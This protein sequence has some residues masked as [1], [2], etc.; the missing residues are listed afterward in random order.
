ML[1]HA[2]LS[3]HAEHVK[4][5]NLA[6]CRMP[7]K[8]AKAC[9]RKIHFW[10]R[11][12][13]DLSYNASINYQR[14]YA[15]VKRSK[16]IHSKYDYT[17]TGSLALKILWQ[18]VI[19]SVKSLKQNVRA[20]QMTSENHCRKCVT[21]TT[22]CGSDQIKTSSKKHKPKIF[23]RKEQ[24]L[25]LAHLG[26]KAAELATLS[27]AVAVCYPLTDSL[28]NCTSQFRLGSYCSAH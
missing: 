2:L 21:D 16:L 19:V 18:N 23:L 26:G 20:H 7:G 13:R 27:H 1:E 5:T 9:C 6:R 17:I 10:P 11:R 14:H 8:K 4:H 25:K 28:P 22:N 15:P 3:I 24:G 12:I